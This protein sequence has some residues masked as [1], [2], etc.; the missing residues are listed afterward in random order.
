MC[1]QCLCFDGVG[2]CCSHH[3]QLYGLIRCGN[4]ALFCLLVL[5][6]AVKV[7]SSHRLARL[8]SRSDCVCVC[9]RVGSTVALNKAV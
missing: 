9:V 6:L 2:A 3:T 4:A 5:Y 8:L 7:H 1:C